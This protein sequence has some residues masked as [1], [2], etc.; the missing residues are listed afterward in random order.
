MKIDK[1]ISIPLLIIISLIFISVLIIYSDPINIKIEFINNTKANITDLDKC[2]LTIHNFVSIHQ[3][4][5][6]GH[7]N[8]SINF[9]TFI[10]SYTRPFLLE[11]IQNST[12][13]CV[14][15]SRK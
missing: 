9:K 6:F 12:D 8:D 11:L 5:K 1:N 15:C 3:K 14:C 10:Y 13:D 7:S 2:Y 4:N